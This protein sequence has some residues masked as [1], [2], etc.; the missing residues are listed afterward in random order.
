L[1]LC[2]FART[3]FSSLG[4]LGVLG[5]KRLLSKPRLAVLISGVGRNLQAILDGIAAGR[6]PAAAAG[7]VSNRP[8][9]PGLARAR[10]AGV[11]AAVVAHTDFA[12][13][14][15]FDAELARALEQLRPD[16]VAMAGFMRVLGDDFIARFKG[17]M[18]NIHPSLLPKYRGLYTHRRALAAGDA[19]HGASV[20][21]V[22]EDLDGG[23]VAIQGRFSVR[24]EDNEQTLAD[25]VMRE[26]E[27]KIYPQALA[28]MARGE[29]RFAGGR[30]SFRGRPLPA[31]L[32]LAD[33]EPEFR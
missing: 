6:I 19:E 27:L 14:A 20:H 3:L 11:P 2:V 12:D 23:P 22:T 8:D 26:V 9:A 24:P 18:V 33:L 4:E 15:A 25:R 17:R 5:E 30:L 7:V 31:P 13:R 1:R 16:I 21:Y 28:W 29:L 10:A 32:T